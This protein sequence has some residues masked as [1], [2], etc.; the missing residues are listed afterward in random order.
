MHTVQRHI[1]ACLATYCTLAFAFAV[2]LLCA[3]FALGAALPAGKAALLQHAD[4]IRSAAAARELDV[5][6]TLSCALCARFAQWLTLYAGSLALCCTP[7][8]YLC[9]GYTGFSVGLCSC[10]LFQ[11]LQ[12]R[13]ILAVIAGM[14]P[15]LAVV[16]PAL[17]YA[18]CRC[19][20][21]ARDGAIARQ[22]AAHRRKGWFARRLSCHAAAL[23]RP[24]LWLAMGAALEGCVCPLLLGVLL[25]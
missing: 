1:A 5:W 10:I 9:V 8:I 7:L 25:G 3:P 23:L 15:G 12:W 14:L 20:Y 17:F 22:K 2:G 19:L 11:G 6:Q 4:A 13:A 16:L 18:S 21:L 24:G